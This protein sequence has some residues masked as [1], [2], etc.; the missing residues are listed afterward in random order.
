MNLSRMAFELRLIFV[1]EMRE[2]LRDRRTL[3][4]ML[5]FPLV[6]YPLLALLSTQVTAAR[7]SRLDE[8]PSRVGIPAE[9]PGHPAYKTITQ[10]LRT[11]TSKE[12]KRFVLLEN[13]KAQDVAQERIDVLV[14]PMEGADVRLRVALVHD[15]ARETSRR[16][17]ARVREHLEGQLPDGCVLRYSV[18]GED[19]STDEARSGYLLSRVLP[20]MVVLMLLLGA[21]YPAIDATAGERERGTLETTLVMPVQA[22]VLLL[23]KILSVSVIAILTGLAN[24]LSMA[25]TFVQVLSMADPDKQVPIPWV[26]L[27]LATVGMLPSA[28]LFSSLMVAAAAIART[29][30]EAQNLLTPLYSLFLVPSVVASI[31]D[32]PL[33]PALA[34]VPGVNITLYLRDLILADAAPLTTLLVLL[35]TALYAVLA[36]RLA[37]HLWNPERLLAIRDPANRSPVATR[38][39]VEATITAPDSLLAFALA[40]VIFLASMPLQMRFHVAGLFAAQWL[41]MFGFVFVYVR[42]RGWRV[43]DAIGWRLPSV[44]AAVGAAL[45]GAGA[46]IVVGTLTEVVAKPPAEVTELLKKLL[47]AEG[48]RPVWL[49]FL[50]VAVTPAICEEVLFRGPILRGMAGS[51]SPRV[52]IAIQAAMFSLFH[53]DLYRLLPT[54]CLGLMLG[55]LALRSR[56]I[57]PGMVAHLFNNGIVILLSAYGAESAVEKSAPTHQFA[58]VLGASALVLVGIR[59]VARSSP[60]R[61]VKM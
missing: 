50:L 39:V 44:G 16:A 17:E 51:F 4:V 57:V 2:T 42:L 20:L 29:F 6:V 36:M 30:K 1:K 10:E 59:T 56:S 60:R 35:S 52:A 38:T 25:L 58:L 15:S 9:S 55:W 14:K 46:W 33:T 8:R 22:S 43:A 5:L 28:F 3:L 23:A 47:L 12:P 45:M 27:L 21:F 11:L 54:F 34:F 53:L 37:A 19:L 49:T 24:L 48:D 32:Y 13:A 18:D 41:G 61:S 7:E 31:G 40:F 26:R